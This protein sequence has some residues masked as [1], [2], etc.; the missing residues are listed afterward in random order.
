MIK[1][2]STWARGD[3]YFYYE[4]GFQIKIYISSWRLN[5]ITSYPSHTGLSPIW[6]SK[7]LMI[8]PGSQILSE[9]SGKI[10]HD[11][12]PI[13]L[14]NWTITTRSPWVLNKLRYW[15]S[16]TTTGNHIPGTKH[17]FRPDLQIL[18]SARRKSN[19]L[20]S[21]PPNDDNPMG[22]PITS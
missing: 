3:G 16:S 17:L 12:H 7:K 4:L 8:P 18:M 6:T 10:V 22:P 19:S 20:M 11:R 21:S 9:M 1:S 5:T 14:K 15:P 13:L 2:G